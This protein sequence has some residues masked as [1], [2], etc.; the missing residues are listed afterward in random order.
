VCPRSALAAWWLEGDL[1]DEHWH[2][3]RP[4]LPLVEHLHLQGWGEPLLH[5]RLESMVE[6]AHAAGCRVGLTSN[7]DF[8]AEAIDWIVAAQVDVV[9]LS[10]A[11]CDEWN[12]RLRDDARSSRWIGS[13][14]GLLKKL[15]RQLSRQIPRRLQ[16]RILEKTLSIEVTNAGL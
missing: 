1:S 14:M 11:A 8:L 5:P 10:V 6:D 4:D 9:A 13:S 2:R 3:L 12:R 7:G 15:C 16:S